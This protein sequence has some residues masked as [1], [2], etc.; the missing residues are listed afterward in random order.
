MIDFTNCKRTK[1]MY[2]GANGNKIGIEYQGE[3]Y[4]LKFPAYAKLNPEMSYTNGCVSEYLACH[5]FN[6][7]G[8]PAQE[9]LLG[10]YA[11]APGK[12]KQ[13]V[14]CKDFT[15][16]AHGI[17]LQDFA[18]LKNTV[19]DSIRNGYGTDLDSILESIERQSFMDPTTLSSHFWDMF[20]I[21]EF[22]GNPDR[23]NGNWGFLYDAERDEI[24]FAPVY[25][26]GSSLLPQADELS[27]H[28]M[29]ISTSEMNIRIYE[30]PSSAIS[31]NGKRINYNAFNELHL[32]EYPEY[33]RALERIVPKIHMD[34]IHSI[35]SQTPGLSDLHK[36]FYQNFLY[37][38]KEILLSNTLERAYSLGMLVQN[39]HPKTL[40]DQIRLASTHNF[41]KDKNTVRDPLRTRNLNEER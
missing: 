11:V 36:Q 29:L 12:F 1:Q 37:A 23:H 28:K 7:L 41:I 39:T 25:D 17:I 21:D 26:C 16:P 2:N 3:R 4:M 19:I 22:I 35:L 33:A 15:D 40:D 34:M 13:V 5:I 14:A 32:V 20:V 10:Q 9:T 18:S 6:Q 24:S 8:I 30:R 38:R 27:I 31:L